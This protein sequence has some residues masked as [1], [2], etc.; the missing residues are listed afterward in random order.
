[1]VEDK[2]LQT[3]GVQTEDGGIQTD[4]PSVD[5]SGSQTDTPTT[6]ENGTQ[7]EVNEEITVDDGFF[8]RFTKPEEKKVAIELFEDFRTQVLDFAAE[9]NILNEEQIENSNVRIDRYFKRAIRD[10]NSGTPITRYSIFDFP[11]KGLLV[12][13]AVIFYLISQ[14]ILQLRN[15]LDYSDAGLS[16]GMFNKTGQYQSWAQFLLMGYMQAKQDFKRSVLPSSPN[17]GFVGIGSEFGYYSGWG[18]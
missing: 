6:E 9:E 11:D 8:D 13:G 1:M 14:G 15:Q 12:E 4:P 16:I 18:E 3:D 7:T 2:G 10:L 5:E 17:A